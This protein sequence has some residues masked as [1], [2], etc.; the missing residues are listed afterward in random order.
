[1]R[2]IKFRAWDKRSKKF[3]MVDCITF[4]S[5]TKLPVA[6]SLEKYS[7]EIENVELQ[8]FTGL[9]D[10]QGKEIFE[11]DIL[12]DKDWGFDTKTGKKNVT[13]VVFGRR[14][15]E[16]IGNKTVEYGWGNYTYHP[17]EIIGN[18]FENKSLL[19]DK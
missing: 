13:E 1:M 14:G 2:K 11:G 4:S 3:L 15:F 16:F 8:Q 7:T 18:I 19:Q 17:C 6:V 10:K 5:I 9:H 12:W